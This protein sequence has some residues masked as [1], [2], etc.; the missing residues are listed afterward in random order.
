MS[1]SYFT[2]VNFSIYSRIY[3]HIRTHTYAY[4]HTHFNLLVIRS[5][6]DLNI[7]L[8]DSWDVYMGDNI[9]MDLK[10]IDREEVDW[11]Y[12]NRTRK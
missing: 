5:D 3:I 2:D 8:F 4:I 6:Q 9:K 10:K 7:M 1:C 11:I 12:S